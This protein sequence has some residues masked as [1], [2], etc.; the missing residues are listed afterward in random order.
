VRRELVCLEPSS[1]P[2]LRVRDAALPEPGRGELLVRVAAT[3]INPIDAKRAAGYGQRLLGLKGAGRFPLVLGNDVAGRVEAVGPGVTQFSVG[4]SVFG[5][6]GTGKRGGAHASHVVVPQSQLQRAPK[7]TDAASVAVLPYSFTTMWLALRGAGLSAG[8]AGGKRVLVLGAAG[9]LG[10]LALATLSGWGSRVSAICDAGTAEDCRALGAL[11]TVERG[12]D[13][14]RSLPT[15]FHAVLNFASWD[16]EPSLVS[17]LSPDALGHATTVHPL[18]GHFDRLGWL[19]GALASRRDFS[20][21]RVAVRQ[22]SQG[23]RYA[24]TVFKPDPDALVALEAGLRTQQVSLPVGLSVPLDQAAAAFAHVAAG[25]P[26][27][28]VLLP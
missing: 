5:L 20:A 2:R 7:G 14:I 12:P 25:K 11:N 27:R 3:S 8:N 1:P 17:R 28:A 23:A 10:R 4:Q 16:D 18:L 21:M 9:A 13:V 22:R 24:W 6:V 15:D 26:G 19:R